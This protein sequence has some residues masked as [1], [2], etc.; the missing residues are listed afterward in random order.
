MTNPPSDTPT[1]R[2]PTPTLAAAMDILARDIQ[3]QDGVANAAI[4][5]AAERLRTLERE[6]AEA[7]AELARRGRR[8]GFDLQGINR[9]VADQTSALRAQLSTAERE[10]RALVEALRETLY[11]YAGLGEETDDGPIRSAV[12]ERARSALASAGQ[13][14]ERVDWWAKIRQAWQEGFDL[15]RRYGDNHAHFDGEQKERHWGRLKAELS[16]GQGKAEGRTDAE[17]EDWLQNNIGQLNWTSGAEPR[18]PHVCTP[19][20]FGH[21]GETVRDAIDQAIDAALDRDD[22][23]R[24]NRHDA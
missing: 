5:E 7:K 23:S 18:R 15:C 11:A 3:S 19:K 10:K 22:A 17:R 14:S 24:E 13:G 16:A 21:E 4:A 12:C 2:T 1:P 8:D 6:L 9:I 20:D